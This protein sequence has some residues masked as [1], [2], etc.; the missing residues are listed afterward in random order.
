M[1][2]SKSAP[3]PS[4]RKPSADEAKEEIL[5]M[6]EKTERPLLV[7]PV[8]VRLPCWSLQATEKLFEELVAE[9]RMRTIT[10]AEQERFDLREGYVLAG[11]NSEK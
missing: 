1:Q 8:S 10:K 3:P 2:R 7:G 4:L 11:V 9:G 6:G 5:R